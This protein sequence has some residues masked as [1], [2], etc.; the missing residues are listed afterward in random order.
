MRSILQFDHSPCVLTFDEQKS[1]KG[2]CCEPPPD[3]PNGG[4]GNNNNNYG[5]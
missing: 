5:G 2:G 3:P 4:E 1:V